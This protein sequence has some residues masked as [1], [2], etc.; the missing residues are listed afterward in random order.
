MGKNK[1]YRMKLEAAAKAE[2]YFKEAKGEMKI[3]KEEEYE[4]L[5]FL[6]VSDKRNTFQLTKELFAY[7]KAIS[8]HTIKNAKTALQNSERLGAEG[9]KFRSDMQKD[10]RNAEANDEVSVE[11]LEVPAPMEKRNSKKFKCEKCDH[12]FEN[13]GNFNFHKDALHKNSFNS[14]YFDA[15]GDIES[16]FRCKICGTKCKTERALNEHK[17]AVWFHKF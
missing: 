2:A 15:V 14:F 17:I 10:V 7:I 8:A 13:E 9:E 16:K 4:K 12:D 5:R 11:K 3:I 1:S 6:L